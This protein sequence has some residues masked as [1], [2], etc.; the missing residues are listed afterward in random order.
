MQVPVDHVLD[1]AHLLK[2]SLK[3]IGQSFL[4]PQLTRY[5]ALLMSSLLQLGEDQ[6]KSLH[7][8]LLILFQHDNLV[9][10]LLM[11]LIELSIILQML[12]IFFNRTQSITQAIC[13]I[14]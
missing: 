5:I 1:R 7:E 8:A 14:V 3:I 4:V 13:F 9:L 10:I 2:L 11:G 6:I 12:P